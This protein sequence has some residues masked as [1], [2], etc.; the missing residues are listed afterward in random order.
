[1]RHVSRVYEAWF[2]LVVERTVMV[3]KKR[4]LLAGPLQEAAGVITQGT[5]N[6]D[7]SHGRNCFHR[8]FQTQLSG[9]KIEF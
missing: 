4:S 3:R 9:S 5:D 7:K 6:T 1:M 8:S 2:E